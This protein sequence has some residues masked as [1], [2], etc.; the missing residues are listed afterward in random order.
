[1]EQNRRSEGIMRKFWLFAA[2][3]GVALVFAGGGDAAAQTRARLTVYTALENDQLQPYKQAFEA[4]NPDV[5]I[6][7][8]RD[9]TGV[10]TARFLA[11]KDN[12][13]ADAIWGLAATS[14]LIFD[15]AGLIEP[16]TPKG[17]EGLKPALRSSAQPMVYTGVEAFLALLCVNTAEQ[18]K[19]GAPLPQ[20][21]SDLTDPKFRNQVVMPHPASSGTGYMQVVSWIKTMGEDK[22]WAFMDQLHQNIAAYLHSGSAPCVQ[23]ARGERIVG[24]GL[25]MRGVR[26][27]SQ[28]APLELVVP[29]EGLAWDLE[30]M[31]IVKGTK[32]LAA[33]Q[34]LADWSATRKASELY[35][36]YYAVVAH[37]DVTALPANYPTAAPAAM[38]AMDFAFMAQNR[39]RILAEWTR[40]Y[41]SKAAPK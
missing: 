18:K 21:W 2:L 32:N 17:A 28:G 36:K 26:E 33:A 13:R 23:A 16:Y 10:I 24:I 38:T 34:K 3:A 30:A 19:A 6:V 5:E 35:S 9:S 39:D 29:K 4:D 25:D 27:K 11:E 1:M 15:Q 20:S 12:P 22:A 14:I 41:E 31:A 7:W 8:Q 40:R 37:S